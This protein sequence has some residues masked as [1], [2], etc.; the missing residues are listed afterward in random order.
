MNRGENKMKIAAYVRVSTHEQAEEG[1]SIPAQ[2]NRLEAYALS[3]GWEIV[4]WY[5]DE[6]QS[7]KDL[8]RTE[9]TRMLNDLKL[10]IFDCVLVYR[11][12]R[13]TRSVQNLYEL[14]NTF[15]KHDVKFKSATEVYDTT[16]AIGRLFITIVSALAQWERENLGER[17]SMG[18]QQ[19][20]K[21]G[22]WTVSKP[23]MGYDSKDGILTINQTE[24]AIVKEIYSL[25]LSGLGMWKIAAELNKRGLYTRNHKPWGQNSIAYILKNPIYIGNTRYNYRVNTDQYFEITDVAPA[26][27][28]ENEFNLVQNM[29]TQRNNV[30]PRQAT[31][32]FIFSKVLKC[33]R[34]GSTLIG[35][36]SISKRG[37]KKYIS[38]NYYCQNRKRG[39]C[40]MPLINQNLLEQKF[41]EMIKKWDF[42]QS[43]NELLNDEKTENDNDYAETIKTLENELKSIE[44]RREKWQ[45]AWANEMIN[46]MDFKKRMNE[47]T[48]K[49]KMIHKELKQLTPNESSNLDNESIIEIMTNLQLQWENMS[50]EIKKQFV[51]IAIQSMEIDKLNKD[52]NPG[53][54]GIKEIKFN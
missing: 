29:M 8:N 45:F 13:L 27:V 9:L 23:P 43:A 50:D 20:A 3:Q 48:E 24:S 18:M 38:Y 37:E 34:C 42:K 16:T 21:E 54:I 31:S 11:L 39:L 47:E 49:E 30:H 25:Y 15:D 28:T 10:G 51:L 1:Y 19:K 7:A 17:V 53:S 2:K 5:V 52:K 32:K 26:I 46:D 6:G 14:L 36:T 12:D 33:A 44:K 4:R 35:K 22:L 40:D 41:L